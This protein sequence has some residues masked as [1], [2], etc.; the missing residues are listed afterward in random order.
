MNVWGTIVGIV[1]L[2]VGI[3]G[4]QQLGGAFWVEPMFNGVTLLVAIGLAGFAGR[5]RGAVK[6]LPPPAPLVNPQFESSL[7]TELPVPVPPL[8]GMSGKGEP[9]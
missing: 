3:S 7:Q 5:K 4:L 1:I 2:A 8:P 9:Q 6:R